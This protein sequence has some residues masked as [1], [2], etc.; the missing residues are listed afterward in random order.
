[1]THNIF[2]SIK[3]GQGYYTN[4]IFSLYLYF[5]IVIYE[6]KYTPIF[7]LGLNIF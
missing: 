3:Q 7:F 5:F 1:M 2:K 4:I 6:F